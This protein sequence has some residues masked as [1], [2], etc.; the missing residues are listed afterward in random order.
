ML[1]RTTKRTAMEHS[2]DQKRD[3]ICDGQT[4]TDMIDRELLY[5]PRYLIREVGTCNHGR[6]FSLQWEGIH[7]FGADMALRND[8]LMHC[9][10]AA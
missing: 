6:R 2:K 4:S 9:E 7:M 10:Y 3:S 1:V 8:L 5:L